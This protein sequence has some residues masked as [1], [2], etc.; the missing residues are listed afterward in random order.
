MTHDNYDLVIQNGHI[1]DPDSGWDG[2]GNIA[3]TNGKIAAISKDTLS[4][5]RNIDATGL[6]VAPGFIDLHSHS[7]VQ[8]AGNWMQAFDGVT[9]ALELELGSLPVAQVYENYAKQG[10]PLNYGI[11]SSAIMARIA[12][13]ENQAPQPTANWYLGAYADPDW[14]VE[15][16][17]SEQLEKI[18]EL[19]EQGLKEGAIGI[20][21][22]Y[23]YAP[24]VGRKEYFKIAELAKK[25]NVPTYTHV[26]YFSTIEPNSSYE[27]IEELI[28]LSFNP[29]AHMHIVHVNSTAMRDTDDVLQLITDGIKNGANITVES[30]PYAAF[31]APVGSQYLRADR[32]KERLGNIN[33]SDIEFLGKPLD[34]ASLVAMQKD[35][36]GN[37]IVCHFMRPETNAADAAMLAKSNLYP[38]SSIGSDSV[39]WQ[40]TSNDQMIEDGVWPLPEGA[41]AHPRSSGCFARFIKMYVRDQKSI[42]LMEAIRKVSLIPAQTL[43]RSTPQMTMKGRLKVGADADIVVFDLNKV[44]DKAT[45]VDPQ[46]TSTGMTYVIV[47]G[48][49]VIDNGSLDPKVFPGQPVRRPVTA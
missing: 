3:V 41:Y 25:Y 40:M 49:P 7:M 1:I 23:G 45:F 28:G 16:A 20:G 21:C 30:Y 44:E 26:R 39:P 10:R 27:A 4:G 22:N 48:T 13:F 33:A 42:S 12:V 19:V 37:M 38:G 24:A 8:I 17:N 43:E 32:W 46:L 6:Y 9:T 2:P 14:Q 31:S 47:N 5:K 15:L 35:T 18:L 34:D 29:G 36:P 11:S